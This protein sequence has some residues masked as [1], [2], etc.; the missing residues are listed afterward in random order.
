MLTLAPDGLT[1]TYTNKRKTQENHM[2]KFWEPVFTKEIGLYGGF[3]QPCERFLSERRSSTPEQLKHHLH[4]RLQM[5]Y[6]LPRCMRIFFQLG[7][8]LNLHICHQVG[9]PQ[10]VC[11]QRPFPFIN[12]QPAEVPQ[13]S[14]TVFPGY[15]SLQN[16]VQSCL[17][18]SQFLANEL[19]AT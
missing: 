11:G 1:S 14:G 4:Y 5:P 10:C 12:S 2:H 17:I 8:H 6:F 19:W 18:L 13:L 9:L 15:N 16:S 3:I 7:Q